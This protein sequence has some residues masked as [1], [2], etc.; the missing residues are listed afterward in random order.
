MSNTKFVL[1]HDKRNSSKEVP[2]TADPIGA[3]P[4]HKVPI[5]DRA[6]NLRGVMG[7]TAGAPTARRVGSLAGPAKLVKHNGRDC[8]KET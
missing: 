8:W 7:R 5:L 4:E 3:V 6:G 2:V 1:D